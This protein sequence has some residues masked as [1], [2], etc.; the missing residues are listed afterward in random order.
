[1]NTSSNLPAFQSL[2]A[3]EH[4]H[5]IQGGPHADVSFYGLYEIHDFDIDGLLTT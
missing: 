3:C 2:A 1:M 5:F 4:L